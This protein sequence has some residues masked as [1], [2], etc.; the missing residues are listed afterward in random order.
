M[1]GY[2]VVTVS[3]PSTNV[4]AL[5]KDNSSNITVAFPYDPQLGIESYRLVEKNIRKDVS[6]HTLRHS[7]ATHLLESGTDLR[8][9]PHFNLCTAFI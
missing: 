7:F 2:G 4:I 8:Y 9:T 5:G 6:L 1:D 3:K